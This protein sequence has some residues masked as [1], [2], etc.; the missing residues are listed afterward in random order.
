MQILTIGRDDTN[1]IVMN[2]SM[3]SRHHA[4]LIISD[5]GEVTIRDLGS[6]NGTFVNGNRIRESALNA[7]DIVKCGTA[8]LDWRE[9]MMNRKQYIT[10]EAPP[11]YY[12]DNIQ[13]NDQDA[14]SSILETLKYLTT[15]IFDTG[16]LFRASWNKIPV[17]LFFVSLQFAIVLSLSLYYFFQV[18][19]HFASQVLLPLLMSFV[20]FGLAQFL[21][22]GLLSLGSKAPLANVLLGSSVYSFLQFLIFTLII[23]GFIPRIYWSGNLRS[24]GRNASA[25]FAF[26]LLCLTFILC[27]FV[28]LIIFLYNYFRSTG[29]A[30]SVSIHFTIFSL[31]LNFLLQTGLAYLVALLW[32][33]NFINF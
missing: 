18:E 28:S 3:V 10:P 33:D 15:R 22:I 16:E 25:E 2:D 23:F 31:T 21:T 9:F 32:E 5:Q 17:V 30:K 13:D 4:Q 20:L 19:L 14:R 12:Q 26:D 24:W 7:G 8:F 11:G 29:F 6:S 1:Q 27:I